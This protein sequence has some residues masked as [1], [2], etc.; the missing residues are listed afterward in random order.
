MLRPSEAF[1]KVDQNGTYAILDGT[2]N[3]FEMESTHIE[4]IVGSKP[5]VFI[6]RE[7]ILSSGGFLTRFFRILLYSF[8]SLF[9]V[10][11][12]L[13]AKRDRWALLGI[14]AVETALLAKKL[15]R[16]GVN[17]VYDY[18][19]YETDSNLMSMFLSRQ[20]ISMTKI[21]SPGPLTTH[22]SIVISD[23]LW[24]CNP[25]QK[26]EYDGLLQNGTIQVNSMAL[27]PQENA[28]ELLKKKKTI[29][30]KGSSIAFYSHGSWLR[31]SEHHSDDG[32]NI[33]ETEQ[34]VMDLLGRYAKNKDTVIEVYP[35][36][37][38]K[39]NMEETKSHYQEMLG[40]AVVIHGSD[41]RTDEQFGRNDLAIV[42]FST[43]LYDRLFS[44][45]K[46]IVGALPQKDF[47]EPESPL[48]AIRFE[49]ANELEALIATSLNDSVDEFFERHTLEGFRYTFFDETKDA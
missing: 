9:L 48:G 40:D 8:Q 10:F 36:P 49:N 38:E 7:Q 32:L 37:R 2:F 19:P 46:T 23:E 4:K 34:M 27:K 35:H 31:K 24:L 29:S 39:K 13:S 5:R 14:Q 28:F 17:R 30:S 45:Y 22:N 33:Y 15:K 47:P 25:Y 11:M 12:S 16:L 18:I 42:A 20:G 44:G 21:P 6:A 41:I 3:F 1:R 26:Y 43:I